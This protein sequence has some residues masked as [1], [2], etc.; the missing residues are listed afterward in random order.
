MI[1]DH[2]E[3][4]RQFGEDLSVDPMAAAA[5]LGMNVTLRRE[6]YQDRARMNEAVVSQHTED[7]ESLKKQIDD[8]NKEIRELTKTVEILEEQNQELKVELK[9]RND[10]IKALKA[11]IGRLESDKK[12][13]EDELKSVKVKVC[14]M[15]K[16]IRELTEAKMA[17]DEKNMELQENFDKATGKMESRNLVLKKEIKEIRESQHKEISPPSAAIPRA[18]RQM[19]TPPLPR[20]LQ[21][22]DRELHASLSLGE[23]CSQLQ[24]KLYKVIFPNSFMASRNYKMKNIR[25]DLEKL[26]QPKEDK[27][28]SRKKWDEIRE[29]LTWDEYYEDAMKSLQDSRNL[30]A[31]PSPLTEE[32]LNRAA[33]IMDSKGNLKGYLSL[34]RVHELISM[35]KQLCNHVCEASSLLVAC[36]IGDHCVCSWRRRCDWPTG[37]CVYY[38]DTCPPDIPYDC[39]RDYYCPRV[40]NKCCCR[41]NA[42]SVTICE[43][44]KD[45]IS[46]PEGEVISV[47]YASYGRHDNHTCPD[48]RIL[49]T[50]CDAGN[51]LSIVKAICDN[52]A[53]C[54]LFS[55]NSVFGDPC[56]GIYKYL[57]VD[58]KCIGGINEA[59]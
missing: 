31:H 1:T 57:E 3:Q 10:E 16:D 42:S 2:E 11:R 36:C 54:N 53:S 28:R 56:V 32:M 51:S 4:L 29:K 18:G 24:N 52:Q 5:L 37:A 45:T 48:P 50:N 59:G 40:R 20:H 22:A 25:R 44:D 23:L 21:I 19:L 38:N 15:E 47:K 17:Q 43:H 30:D 55:S 58:Y 6:V 8:R 33:E 13:L 41:D 27:D 49:T 9:S 39:H 14:R 26:P 46:C 34:K 12:D 7:I 35:W